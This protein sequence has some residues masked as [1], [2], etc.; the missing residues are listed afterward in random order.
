MSMVKYDFSGQVALVTGA[1][2]GIG[3]SLAKHYGKNGADVVAVDINQNKETVPYN[4]ATAEELEE[5]AE[6]VEEEG[7]EALTLEADVSSEAQVQAAV[8]AAVDQFGHI[9][10]LA[11]NAGISSMAMATELDEEAW[12]EVMETNL[13]GVWLCSK[14]VAKHFIE[15]SRSGKIVNA[16]SGPS[17]FSGIPLGNSHYNSSKF[18][19][20]GFTKTLALELAEHEVNV[21]AVAPT[22]VE[23]PLVEG[24]IENY[25]QDTLD[26]NAEAWAG[27][28]TVFEDLPSSGDVSEAFMYLSSEVADPITGITLPVDAGYTAK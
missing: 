1:A 3:R 23:T 20:R 21:N 18:G 17:G 28:F 6:L 24:L 10:I 13:K 5:T 19:I 4:L 25:G 7:Q 14:H 26:E 16:S 11:N 22:A 12:D 2:H 9:D 8:E 27:P 15:D